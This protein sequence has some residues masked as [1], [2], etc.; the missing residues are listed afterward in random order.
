M[1]IAKP[2][3]AICASSLPIGDYMRETGIGI[4]CNN[5]D[6]VVKSL[7]EIWEWKKGGE[8][9]SWYSPISGA[10][11]QY[12]FRSMAEKMSELCEEVYSRSLHPN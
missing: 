2:A 8:T 10:I 7:V 1:M 6:Q 12:T 5:V 3:I 9:P 11:E 4:D